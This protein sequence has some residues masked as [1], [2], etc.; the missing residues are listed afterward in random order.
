MS[1]CPLDATGPFAS[2]P[3]SEDVA[4]FIEGKGE[5]SELETLLKRMY[6]EAATSDREDMRHIAKFVPGLR[7]HAGL[8]EYLNAELSP[9]EL[10]NISNSDVEIEKLLQESGRLMDEKSVQAMADRVR[11]IQTSILKPGQQAEL[12]KS[13]EMLD[14]AYKLMVAS[15]MD[16]R[17]IDT[18]VKNFLHAFFKLSSKSFY[19]FGAGLTV[20]SGYDDEAN[21][22]MLYTTAILLGLRCDRAI[23]FGTTWAI[24]GHEIYHSI[25][26]STEKRVGIDDTRVKTN[27]EC[28]IDHMLRA[29]ERYSEDENDT[30]LKSGKGTTGEDLPDYEGLQAAYKLF[31]TTGGLE[32]T[33]Y[34]D[35]PT[36]TRSRLF[37]YSWAAFWCRGLGDR[38]TGTGSEIHSFGYLR[39]NAPL[40]LLRSFHKAFNCPATSRM[41]QLYVGWILAAFRKQ[42]LVCPLNSTGPFALSYSLP[43]DV[44]NYIEESTKV[45]PAEAAL[46]RMVENPRSDETDFSDLRD[47]AAFVN[48]L[49][50]HAGMLEYLRLELTPEELHNISSYAPVVEDLIRV[51][52]GQVEKSGRLMNETS[53]QIMR[54]RVRTIQTAIIKP[55]QLDQIQDAYKRF[56]EAYCRIM[57]KT[58][59]LEDADFILKQFMVAFNK[60]DPN[61]F[62]IFSGGLSVNSAYDHNTQMLYVTQLI[63]GL[64]VDRAINFGAVI[65]TA[66]HEIYHSL[67]TNPPELGIIDE[68]V[69][70]NRECYIQ[71]MLRVQDQYKG[72]ENDTYVHSGPITMQEDL[73]DYEGL[74]AAYQLFEKT[75][76]LDE[77]PYADLPKITRDQLFFYTHAASYCE[78]APGRSS[79]S[80]PLETHSL[81]Y[82]RT[83][84][85]LSLLSSFHKAFKCP[86]DSRM[87]QLYVCP[88]NATEPG[89]TP[90]FSPD[91][92]A[93]ITAK[94][95]S[96]DVEIALKDLY[97]EMRNDTNFSREVLMQ[98]RTIGKFVYGL[99][100]HIGLME[101]LTEEL[102]TD[103]LR[104]LA[105]YEIQIEE[106]IQVILWQ[107]E[108]SAAMLDP[109]TLKAMISRVRTIQTFI[110]K[111]DDLP[112]FKKSYEL[113]EEVYSQMIEKN[114]DPKD[115]ILLIKKLMEA[116]V[117]LDHNLFFIFTSG[118]QTNSA[119]FPNQQ[120]IYT[121]LLLVGLRCD[122]AIKFGSTMAV[123]GHEI[124]H[125][126]L[127]KTEDA[128]EG[129]GIVDQA[130][131]ANREC[132]IGHMIRAQNEYMADENDTQLNS[133]NKTVAEDLS[134]YEGLQAAYELLA[135]AGGLSA[136][137]FL[138][139]D[140]HSL[141]YL[142][143]NAPLSLMRSFHKAFN[144][145]A[146]SR[147]AKL[148]HAAP[149]DK[150]NQI[151]DV[152]TL[153]NEEIFRHD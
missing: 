152:G 22:Q 123:A 7:L 73:P 12:Q 93:H 47:A 61:L 153:T 100:L 33:P 35:L 31:E 134:D 150:C 98:M 4:G 140:E 39:T 127:T 103:E 83:N 74:Q 124:Y 90:P 11:T 62:T 78:A 49:R 2:T 18:V 88:L 15:N 60:L 70:A 1:V 79:G 147:M 34:P 133:G 10:K 57:E 118:L 148:Y 97:L 131:Q 20:N 129:L 30:I 144:C 108:K 139:A 94:R 143:T 8:M 58:R 128:K 141:G 89:A 41:G 66:G 122:R 38:I 101:Y 52:V 125:S 110:L 69:K 6:R 137:L 59:C 113:F 9:E 80:N 115:A 96:S 119:Y 14:G 145:P 105:S 91:V 16:Q 112:K 45:S 65:A 77:I 48:G 71:H 64:R 32:E 107:V 23:R 142:R 135:K 82:L 42:S 50:L 87:G 26:T 56:D 86:A 40:S 84:A 76:G 130:V 37:F 13:Y 55:E 120:L 29:Q 68:R 36:I 136:R 81:G 151:G 109:K 28:Y 117:E 121:T 75:G 149:A 104:E 114:I 95:N 138:R 102:S 132:Y 67:L 146:T 72:E 99:R 44:I 19:I 126:I 85:P 53:L 3:F 43:P 25:L 5:E 106:M 27:R 111:I 24:A 46:I 63:H 17:N 21:A 92:V 54:D 116:F 51:I